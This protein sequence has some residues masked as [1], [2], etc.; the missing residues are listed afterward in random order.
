MLAAEARRLVY[1]LRV[2]Q[3]EPKEGMNL[4]EREICHRMYWEVVAIEK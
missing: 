1:T 2:N 4:I 3:T